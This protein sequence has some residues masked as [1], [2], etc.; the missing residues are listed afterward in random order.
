MMP[1]K[2]KKENEDF[3]SIVAPIKSTRDRKMGCGGKVLNGNDI[4]NILEND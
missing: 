3:A 2:K 1:Q 4:S